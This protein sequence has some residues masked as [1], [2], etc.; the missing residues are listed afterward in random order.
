VLGEGSFS[1]VFL[2][3][4]ISDGAE[5]ALKVIDQVYIARHKMTQAV[6]RER[7]VM[8]MLVSDYVVDLKF[9]FQVLGC[10]PSHTCIPQ[11]I[12]QRFYVLQHTSLK[13]FH[14]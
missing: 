4:R 9:T 14:T 13:N 10:F 6:I 1:T 3:K 2:A 7:H 5:F 12:L 11:L 8:D